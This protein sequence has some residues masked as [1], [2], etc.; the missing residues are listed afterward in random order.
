M[1][2]RVAGQGEVVP[3]V[4]IAGCLRLI[5]L[6]RSQGAGRLCSTRAHLASPCARALNTDRNSLLLPKNNFEIRT[7]TFFFKMKLIYQMKKE[8]RMDE[9][10][11]PGSKY[12]G[13][14]AAVH[15]NP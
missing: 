12:V 1:Y 2:L 4:S 11:S 9:H 6:R 14:S 3:S 7:T 15:A 8:G 10:K 5:H 13:E